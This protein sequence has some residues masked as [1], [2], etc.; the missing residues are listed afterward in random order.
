MRGWTGGRGYGD[1]GAGGGGKGAGDGG[2]V[3]GEERAG[4]GKFWGAGVIPKFVVF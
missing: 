1:N 3:A 2:V 4:V